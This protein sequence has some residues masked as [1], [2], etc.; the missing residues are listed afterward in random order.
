MI[1]GKQPGGDSATTDR[2]EVQTSAVVL[3]VDDRGVAL[4]TDAHGDA[5]LFWLAV[6][7][8][9]FR[10][11][12]TMVDR[13]AQQMRQRLDHA[14]Q[15]FGVQGDAFADQV[16]LHWFHDLFGGLANDTLQTRRDLTER[17]GAGAL[18]IALQFDVELL[19]LAAQIRE[20]VHGL[21]DPAH[22]FAAVGVRFY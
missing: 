5:A 4:Q 3:N 21:F 16:Q 15:Q 19:L 20:R 17:Y 18:N 22:E 13:V 10:C 9:A 6:V 11:F 2:I 8:S 14:F 7:A 12:D 1:L